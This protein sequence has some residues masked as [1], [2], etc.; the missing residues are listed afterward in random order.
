MRVL[1]T[2]F[3]GG[4]VSLKNISSA[5]EI[6][7]ITVKEVIEPFLVR[8]GYIAM[9]PRGRALT[10]KGARLYKEKLK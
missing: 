8:S 9:F 4:P 10:I 1:A 3:N 5:I 6:S 7:E 2:A